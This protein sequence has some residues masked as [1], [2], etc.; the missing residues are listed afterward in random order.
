MQT[1]V[2]DYPED[3]EDFRDHIATVDEKGKRIWMY[4]KQV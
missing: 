4:P 3:T 1:P 2:F